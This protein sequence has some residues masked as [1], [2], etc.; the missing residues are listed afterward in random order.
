MAEEIYMSIKT[1]VKSA[2]KDTQEYGKSIQSSQQKLQS[3]N[4][5]LKEQKDILMFLQKEQIKLEQAQAKMS[6]WEKS[7]SGSSKKLSNLKL[8]IKDQRLAVKDLTDQQ[9]E[10]TKAQKENGDTLLNDIKNYKVFGVSINGISKGFKKLIP[11]AR[12]AFASIKAGMISTGIGALI[13]AFGS[14]VA[15]FT[16]TK[17]GAQALEKV[18]AAVG[19]AVKVF[20]DRIISW[21]KLLLDVVT[22]DFKGMAANA[23]A[24]FMG[25]GDE[26]Q[27]EITLALQLKADLHALADAERELNVE[28]AQRRAEIEELKLKSQDLTLTE[29]ERLEALEQAGNIEKKLMADRVANAEEAVRIQQQQ[30]TMSDNMKADLDALAQKEIDLANIK[31]ESARMQTTLVTKANRIK[32][33]VEAQEKAAQARWVTRQN[34]RIAKQNEVTRANNKLRQ[35]ARKQIEEIEIRNLKTDEAREKKRVTLAFEAEKKIINDSLLADRE[36]GSIIFNL[37]Q[38][39]QGDLDKLTDKWEKIR[40]DKKEKRFTALQSLVVQNQV[41]E[42]TSTGIIVN[43]KGEMRKSE[44]DLRKDQLGEELKAITLVNAENRRL[45]LLSVQDL[46]NAEELKAEIRIKYSQIND[47]AIADNAEKVKEVD[48]E[49]IESA[50][51]VAAAKVQILADTLAVGQKF[52]DVQAA[53]LENNYKKEIKLAEASGKSTEGIEKKYEGKRREQAKKFK[54]MKIAMAMVDTYQSAVA[55]YAAGLQVGG[56]AGLVIGPISAALAVAAGLANIAMIEK[57]PLGGGGGGGGGSTAPT[58]EG[59]RPA[60]QMMSGAFDLKGGVEPEP[61]QAY[62]LTDE[63]TSSQNQLANIRRRATI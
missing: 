6:D 37:E 59:T 22:L 48:N 27:R 35:E 33:S 28:T 14:L 54:A 46:E 55:A 20:I 5:T 8:E 4:S 30:M 2:T 19:A 3:L 17:A 42:L 25:V 31:R 49:E 23:K 36:K 43:E 34:E 53:E 47:I 7:I 24:A 45:E 51:R 58:T 1:D 63:M 32:K 60:P 29:A 9:R 56:P 50:K 26:L 10:L 21:G 18:F 41:L 61:L 40:R 44:F 15:W 52:M 16:Q 12:A 39:N 11:V 57:Q 13:V 62:V 38:V